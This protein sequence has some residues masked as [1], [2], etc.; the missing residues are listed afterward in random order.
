MCGIAGQVDFARPDGMAQRVGAAIAAIAHRGPDGLHTWHSGEAALGHA[1]LSIIDLSTAADQPMLDVAGDVVVV[2]NGEIYNY[3]ELRAQLIGLG[4][5]FRTSSDTE[6]L[7]QGYLEW[8]DEVL[9]RL[10][11]MFALA[12][13]DRRTMRL[14]LARDPLGIKPLLYVRRGAG[15]QFASEIKALLAMSPGARWPIDRQ[16]LHEYLWF[17]NALGPRTLYADIARLE[18]GQCLTFDGSGVRSRKLWRVDSGPAVADTFPVATRKVRELLERA[19]ASHLVSD[20]PVGLMLS[21]GIDSSAIAAFAVRAGGAPLR[22]YS[23]AFDFEDTGELPAAAQLARQLGTEH[24]ELFVKAEEIPAL[25]RTLV[26]CHDEPF[27]DA[28]NIP[29]YLATRELRGEAKVLLQGDGG[30]EM[31]A[32]YRRYSLL[33]RRGPWTALRML[34]RALIPTSWSLPDTMRRA[35]RI[36]DALGAD[37]ALRMALLLTVDSERHAPEQIL[38][39]AGR[40]LLVASDPLRRY[41]EV[42]QSLPAADPVQRMLWVDANV[43]LPDTF[44]EK[45]DR[46][47]MANGVEVRVPFLDRH[48]ADYALRLPSSYKAAHGERKRVLRAALRGIVPDEVLDRPK[49]GFGVPYGNWLR[50]PLQGALLDCARQSRAVR[51]QVLDGKRLLELANEHIARRRDHGFLLWKALHLAAWYDEYPVTA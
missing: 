32:G 11:G 42:L 10:D 21:G 22:T 8:G 7:L 2:F 26:R 5:S 50:G 34:S 29:L 25:V 20:V 37:E 30:D 51:E 28:A 36:V 4:R 24:R 44:L 13:W 41:A 27:A 3:R 33:S 38:G 23:V 45:V 6:A 49:R 46:S 35:L 40:E 15:I 31:F 12:I 1:R 19:V 9:N 18:A 43:L 47:T 16:A 48:L 39:A 14:T 17:G